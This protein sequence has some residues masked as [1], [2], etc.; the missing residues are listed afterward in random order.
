MIARA[1]EWNTSVFKP[2]GKDNIYEV[3]FIPLKYSSNA[4]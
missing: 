3:K 2:S 4:S 1:A